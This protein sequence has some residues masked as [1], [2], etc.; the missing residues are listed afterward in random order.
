MKIEVKLDELL[1]KRKMRSK[2][3]AEK[4]GI[5]Q[6]NLSLI[7]NGHVLGIRFATLIS[8]CNVLDCQPGDLLKFIKEEDQI[9]EV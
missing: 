1:V 7:K 3:L 5:T 9:S 8:L 4:A 2:E 6:A